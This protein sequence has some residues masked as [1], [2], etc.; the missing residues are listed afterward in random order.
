MAHLSCTEMKGHA[1]MHVT[2]MLAAATC[3]A[4]STLHHAVSD[5]H[6]GTTRQCV[7]DTSLLWSTWYDGC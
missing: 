4:R 5:V 7:H 3:T 6:V 2:L 1:L